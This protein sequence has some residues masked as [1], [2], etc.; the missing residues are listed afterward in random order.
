[1]PG[2]WSPETL[3]GDWPRHWQGTPALDFGSSAWRGTCW[4]TEVWLSL[5]K[6]QGLVLEKVRPT[7]LP[8]F[9]RH[10]CTQQTPRASSWSPE[11]TQPSTDRVD[12]TR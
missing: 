5:G 10:G 1:M 7:G 12:T 8:P 4:M 3:Y 6:C 9:P 11:E 2:V